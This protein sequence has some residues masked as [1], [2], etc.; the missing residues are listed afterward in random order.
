MSAPFKRSF[1]ATLRS[2]SAPRREQRQNAT[3]TRTRGLAAADGHMEAPVLVAHGAESSAT[4]MESPT[5]LDHG[6][7]RACVGQ[8]E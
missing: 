4:A 5:T 6:G 2:D 1:E 8:G 3:P 7:E